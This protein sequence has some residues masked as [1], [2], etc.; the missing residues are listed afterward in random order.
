MDDGTHDLLENLVILTD[1]V[2]IKKVQE[3]MT[4]VYLSWLSAICGNS[5]VSFDEE[6][7]W[8]AFPIPPELK[9]MMLKE[10]TNIFGAR[11]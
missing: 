3:E 4:D 6:N 8:N 2:M 11:E 10:I 1:Y 5:P 9:E 7:L